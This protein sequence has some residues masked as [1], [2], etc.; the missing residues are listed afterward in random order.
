MKYKD[1]MGRGVWGGV[2]SSGEGLNG[3]YALT[4]YYRLW[5]LVFVVYGQPYCR[6]FC[7]QA[8]DNRVPLP[9]LIA[10]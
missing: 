2:I 10:A 1:I 5:L 7:L 4:V 3:P 6:V 8:C 9:T